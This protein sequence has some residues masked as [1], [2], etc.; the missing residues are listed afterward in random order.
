MTDRRDQQPEQP[1]FEPEIIPP[2]QDRGR[3]RVFID[4]NGDAHRIYVARP[5]PFTIIA[6]LTVLGLIGLVLLIALLSVALIWI[7][8]VVV[9]VALLIARARFRIWWHQLRSWWAQR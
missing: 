2:G 8:I 5:G 6:V 7:P 4:Q 3:E 9:L 1:R